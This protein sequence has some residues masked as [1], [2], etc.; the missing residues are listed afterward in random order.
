MKKA[1]FIILFAY[2]SLVGCQKKINDT[3]VIIETEFGKIEV[4][5]NN[6]TPEHKANF[7]KLVESKFYNGVIFHRV[8]KNFMIQGGDPTSKGASLRTRVGTG[9]MDYTI[10]AEITY[11]QAFHK[12]GALAM[13]R[14]GDDVNPDK[15]SSGCQFYIVDGEKYTDAELDELQESR[16]SELKQRTLIGLIKKNKT[17]IDSIE[18]LNNRAALLKL[19]NQLASDAEKAIM[20][21]DSLYVIPANVREA[22]KQEGGTPYLDRDYTVFGEVI[23]GIEVV[24]HIANLPTGS[25]DRPTS[26]VIISM[27]IKP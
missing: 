21:S 2:T 27:K 24:H 15:R 1:L 4:L 9:D 17:L 6:T 26:N 20:G 16:K 3:M 7:I 18:K 12:R 10:P 13:A 23:S 8:I 5:L 11:P 14:L 19:Q 22:Y 25:Y